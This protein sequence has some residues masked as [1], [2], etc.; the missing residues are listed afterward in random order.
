MALLFGKKDV[1]GKKTA[2]AYSDSLKK[3]IAH[4]RPTKNMRVGFNVQD[5]YGTEWCEFFE[6]ILEVKEFCAKLEKE[7]IA[8]NNYKLTHAVN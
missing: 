1:M 3:V 4:I 2:V 8:K 7:L 5:V 6:T